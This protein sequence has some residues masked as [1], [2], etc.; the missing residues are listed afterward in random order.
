L[1]VDLPLVNRNTIPF[2]SIPTVQ[3]YIASTGTDH[4][5]P[6]HEATTT[7]TSI[8]EQQVNI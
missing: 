4:Y 8:N 1:V 5:I 3:P 2:A 7:S 6:V